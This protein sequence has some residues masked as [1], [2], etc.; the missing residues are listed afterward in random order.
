MPSENT[1]TATSSVSLHT[2]GVVP[3]GEASVGI[4]VSA[5]HRGEAFA[6]CHWLI[7]RLKEI[8]QRIAHPTG[9]T[10]AEAR[11]L[12]AEGRVFVGTMGVEKRD[13]AL[14]R[15]DRGGQDREPQERA[16]Q[17]LARLAEIRK[18]EAETERKVKDGMTMPG[19]MADIVANARI[20]NA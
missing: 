4:A 3:V 5:A 19:F 13:G 16:E 17:V 11:H 10:D 9:L 15:V 18:A 1:S 12:A 7:D 8:A 6:A 2:A 20:E 14:L